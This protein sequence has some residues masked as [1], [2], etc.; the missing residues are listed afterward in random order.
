MPRFSRMSSK[1]RSYIRP[2]TYAPMLHP[3]LHDDAYSC[4]LSLIIER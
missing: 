4:I 1:V 2:T 3:I